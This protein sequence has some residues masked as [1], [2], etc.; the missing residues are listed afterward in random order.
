MGGGGGGSLLADQSVLD[1]GD[2]T[3][4]SIGME[5]ASH[6]PAADIRSM[7]VVVVAGTGRGKQS[8]RR[9]G[10]P[11]VFNLLSSALSL[12]HPLLL[13]ACSFPLPPLPSLPSA[14]DIS[15]PTSRRSHC[16]LP[17][18]HRSAASSE[19]PAT[20]WTLQDHSLPAPPSASPANHPRRRP[21]LRPLFLVA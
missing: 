4:T 1:G 10:S 20:L 15:M 2:Q 14:S 7:V 8:W 16:P 17:T 13:L 18:T 11:L 5:L 3:E 6:C 21:D 19:W 9:V 12:L